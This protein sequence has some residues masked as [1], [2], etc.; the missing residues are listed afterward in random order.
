VVCGKLLVRETWWAPL[1]DPA[2]VG[3]ETWGGGSL[4]EGVQ[5]GKREL[6]GFVALDIDVLGK[7]SR[8]S[9]KAVP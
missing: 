1:I 6:D 2:L 3:K 5:V 7:R 4:L 8:E 9:Q